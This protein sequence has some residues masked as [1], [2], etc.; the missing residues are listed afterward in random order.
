[1]TV[2]CSREFSAGS[3]A[4]AE[5]GCGWIRWESPGKLAENCSAPLF[6]RFMTTSSRCVVSVAHSSEIRVVSTP[7][8]VEFQFLTHPVTDQAGQHRR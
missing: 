4:Q 3:G 1:M 8:S 7:R 6:I 2:L 5:G